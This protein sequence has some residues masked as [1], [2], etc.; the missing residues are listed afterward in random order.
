MRRLAEGTRRELRE[1]LGHRPRDITLAELS[2]RMGTVPFSGLL[3]ALCSHLLL[4]SRGES[5]RDRR[6][7]FAGASWGRI[8]IGHGAGDTWG[9]TRSI[10]S[11]SSGEERQPSCRPCALPCPVSRDVWGKA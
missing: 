2:S 4:I 6:T 5:R 11:S 9:L 8:A 1:R 7:F 10:V 3:K